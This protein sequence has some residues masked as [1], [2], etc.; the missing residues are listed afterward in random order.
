MLRLPSY[1]ELS[2][3]QDTINN[4]PLHGSYLV[5]GPPGTGKT[6]MAIYRASMLREAGIYSRFMVFNNPLRR[7]LDQ[8]MKETGIEGV[9]TTFFL[10][11]SRWY[12]T[13]FQ[14]NPPQR[15][16]YVLDW[17]SIYRDLLNKKHYDKYQHLIVDEGQDFPEEFFTMMRLIANN[18]TVFADENQRIT[19]ANSTL[20]EIRR[21]VRPDG[22][23]R[24][25][26]NYRNTRA[27][28][29]F[30]RRFYAGLESGIPD[31]PEKEGR[32]PFLVRT[33][34]TEEQIRY[35]LRYERNNPDSDIGVFVASI[36]QLFYVR[37][38]LRGRTTNEV[39]TFVSGRKQYQTLDFT[40]R[41]IRIVA[42]QSAKGLEFD[43]VFIPLLETRLSDPESDLE[44]MRFYVM[45]SRSRQDLYLL[46]KGHESPPILRK[47]PEDL[48]EI[49]DIKG[50]AG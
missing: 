8:A 13:N 41:G 30:A 15:E 9:S 32:R 43:A 20:R 36:E 21:S 5:V 42:Y 26:R 11:F 4:L 29:E 25:T 45:S 23:Y 3:E 35:I 27:V 16:R 10:W 24:L 50:T 22:E 6:V 18:V 44:R 49:Q 38:R 1:Q 12:R 28:A 33:S 19:S 14:R 7:Y 39:Q 17:S 31:L 48:Y 2:K 46:C 40:K 34:D 37:G 47:V